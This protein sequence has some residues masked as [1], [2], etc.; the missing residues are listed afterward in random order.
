MYITRFFVPENFKR[1]HLSFAC[2][3][4]IL[5]FNSE[6]KQYIS[7]KHGTMS[8]GSQWLGRKRYTGFIAGR[9]KKK[10]EDFPNTGND[11]GKIIKAGMLTGWDVST[12]S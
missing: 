5:T 4:N 11:V 12:D 6:K 1:E 2:G 7:I 10:G 3:G 9:E 8:C